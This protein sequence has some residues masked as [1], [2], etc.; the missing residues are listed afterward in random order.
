MKTK[1]KKNSKHPFKSTGFSL[2]ELLIVL[3]ISGLMS[4]VV[5]PNYT[6]VFNAAK[7]NTIKQQLSSIQ[8]GLETY[9]LE[10]GNYPS[11]I[12]SIEELLATL[13]TNN[14]LKKDLINPFTSKPFS[15]KDSSGKIIVTLSPSQN[16]YSLQA[17]GKKETDLIIEKTNH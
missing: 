3:L 15:S 16:E 10:N 9:F 13:K 1:N 6:K 2:I 5:I 7:K 4:S 17:Y 12:S 8:L 14:I 11:N